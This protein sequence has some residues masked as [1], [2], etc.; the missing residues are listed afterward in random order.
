VRPYTTEVYLG[1][2]WGPATLKYSHALTNLFGFAESDGSGYLDASVN[3]EF[4]PGWT[5]NAHAG[6]QRVKG[7]SAASY[8]DW[9]LGVTR[10]FDGGWSLAAA[11]AD[12][13]AERGVY[14]NAFG[15]YLGRATGTLTLS[16]AF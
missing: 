4:S 3:V 7:T 9:K 1:A 8:S 10:S 11:Y 13:N 15:H 2:S 6:H 16:K 12:T 5:L 14:T